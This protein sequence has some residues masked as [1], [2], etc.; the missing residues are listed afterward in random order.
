MKILETRILKLRREGLAAI[1]TRWLRFPPDLEDAFQRDYF[2]DTLSASR[3]AALATI[4][5]IIVHGVLDYWAI[6]TNYHLAWL[7]RAAV[8]IPGVAITLGLS[9][10]PGIRK[11]FQ[12][13][14][15]TCA[16]LIGVGI[17]LMIMIAQPE[18]LA[19]TIY[20][21]ALLLVVLGGF[22]LAQLQ[23]RYALVSSLV[24]LAVYELCAIFSQ[25]LLMYPEGR[26]LFLFSNFM[27]ITAL[28]FAS[29]AGYTLE[30]YRRRD[31]LQRH[32]LLQQNIELRA[33]AHTVAHDLKAPLISMVGYAEMAREYHRDMPAEELEGQLAAIVTN[34]MKTSTIID[35]LLLLASVRQ[36]E[37]IQTGPLNMTT[38]VNDALMRV[39]NI[40]LESGAAIMRPDNWPAAR[41]YAPWVEGVWANLISNAVKYGGEP[42]R[43]EL[44]ADRQQDGTVRFWVRDNGPGLSEEDQ[45]RLFVQFSRLDETR[46]NGHGLGL[47]IVQRTVKKLGGRV[48]IDSARGKGSTF[49]FTLPA[50]D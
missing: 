23:F 6:P 42:P 38:I 27:Y 19:F 43:V 33:Y 15:A 31:F 49:W 48:G 46:A 28:V 24:I 20:F 11:V 47:S 5:I 45:A 4:L 10:A 12:G 1:M 18:E 50:P 7:I 9:Y 39:E 26:V 22:F 8:M 21:S 36:L 3:I 41:G 44:G 35:D 14:M 37:D 13:L 30:Y 32:E 34:G 2:E 40:T 17:C 25:G 29:I 16:T